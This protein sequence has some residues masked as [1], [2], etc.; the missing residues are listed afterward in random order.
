MMVRVRVMVRMRVRWG[1]RVGM[2]RQER[3]RMRGRMVG[4]RGVVWSIRLVNH[5]RNEHDSYD[6]Q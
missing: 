4:W 5:T 1:L 6:M 3:M 2:E